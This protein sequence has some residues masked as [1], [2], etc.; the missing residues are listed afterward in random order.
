[1]H[2]E[3]IAVYTEAKNVLTLNLPSGFILKKYMHMTSKSV[4]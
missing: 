1:M 2:F 4:H 3:K